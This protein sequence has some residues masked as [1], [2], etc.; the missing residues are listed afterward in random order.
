MKQSLVGRTPWS[1]AGPLAGL[2]VLCSL[3]MAAP[4]ALAQNEAHWTLSADI[5][6]A[7][8]GTTV[9][10]RLTAKIDPGWHIYSMTTPKGGGT[11][12][13]VVLAEDPAIE[14]FTQY[15]PK[16]KRQFDSTFGVDVE[17]FD[18]QVVFLL[19]VQLKKDTSADALKLTAQIKYQVCSDKECKPTKKK[20]SFTLA[21]DRSAASA[22][23]LRDSSGIYRS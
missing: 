7:P 3:F 23:R 21:I 5:A 10:L 18:D 1:A 12:T 15:Q 8:P 17:T 20:A 16:P 9:P 19:P 11:P 22:R 13:T 14:S 2:A 6:K 4:A